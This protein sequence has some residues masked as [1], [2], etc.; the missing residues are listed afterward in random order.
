MKKVH[1]IAEL[2]PATEKLDMYPNKIYDIEVLQNQSTYK[3]IRYHA[4]DADYRVFEIVSDNET[5]VYPRNKFVRLDR[6]SGNN[7]IRLRF[8]PVQT[9]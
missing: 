6:H 9:I 3:R 4:S 1:T 2:I 7:F 8:E 5:M